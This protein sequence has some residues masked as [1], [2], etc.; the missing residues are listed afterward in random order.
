MSRTILANTDGFTPVI[1]ALTKELGLMPAVVFGR[2]WRFCQ[3]E[4]GVCKATLETIAEGIGVDRATVQRHAKTLCETGYLKDLTPDLRNR[5]HVYADTG[6]ASLKVSISGVA[7]S[8]VDKS[9]VAQSNVTIA[10]RNADVADSNTHVAQSHMNKV[11]KK[12][13]KTEEKK[14]E[15][16]AGS[17][18]QA[19]QSNI[20]LI[21]PMIADSL[22]DLETEFPPE[23]IVEAIQIAVENNARR[24]KYVAAI[25]DRWK[26]EGKDE[27]KKPSRKNG[28]AA[29]DDNRSKY[30]EGEYA[31]F[32]QS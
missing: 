31:D 4:D 24:L 30:V 19:Y 9:H 12:D 5:P 29:D 22:K 26:R 1:D 23:W 21:T 28:K 6:K 8:N 18:F 32:I 14:E 10:Q 11:F 17:I 13:S 20:G 2:M 16:G 25:L 3:M 27:G 15:E 7:Q